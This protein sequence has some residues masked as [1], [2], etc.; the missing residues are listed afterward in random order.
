MHGS[1][2]LK[3]GMDA[4]EYRWSGY[5]FGN[6][7]GTYGFNSEWTNNP[8]T[9]NTAAPLGQEFA[10][11]LLG[12]PYS[13]S[14]D[15]NTQDTVEAKYLGLF[16]NDDWKIKS[17]LTINMG[18]R[19]EHDFPEYEKY[20]RSLN[21]FNPSAP[22]SISSAAAA[23]YAASP[24]ALLPAS[25]F[26]AVGG[27]TF[28]GGDQNA[29]Y[30]DQSKIF[31]PRAG[32]AW[33]P[34]MFHGKAVV[35]GGAG[36]LVDPI[37]LP[38]SGSSPA[39][40]SSN[41]AYGTLNQPGFSQ[42]T[43]M[44]VTGNNYV[45][46]SATLSNPFPSGILQPSGNKLATSTNLGS[47]I[48]FVD[49]NPRNPYVGRW[50]LSIQYELP[51]QFVLEVAYIGNR[52]NHLPIVTQLDAIPAQYLS[53]SPLRNNAIVSEF[54]GNATNP[55]K[56]LLPNSSSLNGSTVQLQQLLIPYP[57]YTVPVVPSPGTP[58]NGVLMQLNPAGSSYYDSLDVRLQRRLSNN[59][60]LLNNFSWSRLTDRLAYLNDTDPAPE[61]RISSDS[62]PLRDVL[63]STYNL[64]IGRGRALNLQ[65]PWIDGIV[66]GWGLNG[67]LTLQSGPVLT[68]GNYVYLGGGLNYNAHQP[69]G[70]AF[71]ISPFVPPAC[72]ASAASALTS[73]ISSNELA[74]NIRTLDN[75]FNNLRRDPTKQLDVS[76]TKN[77]KF[78][79]RA[80]VQV[81]IEAYNVT[82]RV[83]FGAPNTTP[84][85]SAFGEIGSQANTPRR[86]QS[87]LK[88]VW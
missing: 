33:S 53:T 68:W 4:R 32:F 43:N 79:E 5:T 59:L 15:E 7:S 25:Q 40:G 72:Q 54:T 70:T 64:P 45:S 12:L 48:V 8:A 31:S 35:K 78:K 24:N 22:N 61:K 50:E 36:I 34:S 66:G 83:T 57:Q 26:K 55:F 63:A 28:A 71:N 16:V 75:Q 69:N 6:P 85:S 13:G 81:R 27:P 51:K 17:N 41:V 52:A 11:F 38:I 88:L 84:T 9:S 20:N 1:H 46:P 74:D 82:N 62:R 44:T 42:T 29:I 23:A 3:V 18:L 86:L 77:F 14:L 73:C 30:N 47:N 10:S 56:G 2:T 39:V 76:M 49:P 19:W 67:I 37:L 21:G 87:A 60:T 80:Y 65:N 58:A